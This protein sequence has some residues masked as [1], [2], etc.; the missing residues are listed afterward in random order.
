MHS[1][2][3][4]Q[5]TRGMLWNTIE[6]FFARGG[7]LISGIVMARI[8]MPEDFGLVGMITIFIVVA[9]TLI[10]G[11]LGTGLIQ[12]KKRTAIDFST[13]FVYNIAVSISIY[14]ILFISAPLIAGFYNE[15]LLIKL[16]RILSINI[17]ISS[18]GIVPNTI[19]ITLIDFKTI[20]KI[21]IAS[22]ILGGAF[23]II[24][25][26][27]GYGVWALVVESLVS[28]TVTIIL[29]WYFSSWTPSFLFSSHSFRKLFSFGSK[30][31]VATIINQ[32]VNKI[33]YVAIGK[34]YL[35]GELGF[36][37][38]AK[39][40]TELTADAVTNIL[41]QVSYPVLAFLQD[42]RERMISVFNRVLVMT[43]FIIFP[44]MTLIA[45]LADPLIT[46]VLTDKWLA[47][48][49]LLQW[50][51]FAQIIN[52]IRVINMN[53]LIASGKSGQYLKMDFIKLPV[54]V[55]ALI[56]TIPLGLKAIVLGQVVTAVVA[57][58]F[59]AL[60]SGKIF[61]YGLL[62]QLGDM[63]SVIFVTFIT[64]LIVYIICSFI[65]IL[66]L[67]LIIGVLTGIVVYFSVSY[68]FNIEELKELQFLVRYL[69][70]RND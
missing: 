29:L 6:K 19:F 24:S 56:I 13:V 17:V 59:S 32:S 49:P 20:A 42:D 41:Q 11:G 45:I 50:L 21:N 65:E 70:N 3:K 23:G 7:R 63:I 9:S 48:V 2:L 31:L 69:I 37:S 33:Y 55:V 34:I 25:A 51:C 1:S 18:F 14:V 46:I 5:A 30:I 61:G 66:M 54:A 43:S 62:A 8:L 47:A 38:K 10:N 39:S 57:Y 40:F 60:L 44:L 4:H 53:M 15:P 52:S 35:S 26:L 67:K 22:V 58:I 36:Y 27:L 68:I 12:K 64:A 28:S 16:T